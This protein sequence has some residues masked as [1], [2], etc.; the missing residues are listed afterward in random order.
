MI[1]SMPELVRLKTYIELGKVLSCD[2]VKLDEQ[3]RAAE[4]LEL[5]EQAIDALTLAA[6][7]EDNKTVR[8][9]ISSRIQE[10]SRR[11]EVIRRELMVLEGS[12]LLKMASIVDAEG[13]YRE[14][15]N[16]YK[17]SAELLTQAIEAIIFPKAGTSDVDVLVL[18]QK[19]RY[20]W[21]R[22]DD[23][24][25]TGLLEDEICNEQKQMSQ[26]AA[27]VQSKAKTKNKKS[28]GKTNKKVDISKKKKATKKSSKSK[29]MKKVPNSSVSSFAKPPPAAVSIADIIPEPPSSGGK[30]RLPLH[31]QLMAQSPLQSQRDLPSSRQLE[32]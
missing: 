31:A 29:T 14:A 5:Y 18:E 8:T 4:A 30:G 23:I 12:R 15:L 2:A 1:R 26:K 32:E 11:I 9:T 7:A 25:N 20:C 24:I 19:I 6:N 27:A 28:N 10:Y 17:H 13:K 16:L 22:G 3:G 21:Q